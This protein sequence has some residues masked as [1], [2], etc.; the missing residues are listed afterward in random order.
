MRVCNSLISRGEPA[1][2]APAFTVL[3]SGIY[4]ESWLLEIEATAVQA[5]SRLLLGS[6]GG[7]NRSGDCGDEGGEPALCFGSAA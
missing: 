5:D 2:V 1:G 6:G 3:I 4:E 7:A